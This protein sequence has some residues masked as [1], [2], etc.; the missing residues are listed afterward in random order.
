MGFEG[1]VHVLYGE[2]KEDSGKLNVK[3]LQFPIQNDV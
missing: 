1:T 2:N 3:F